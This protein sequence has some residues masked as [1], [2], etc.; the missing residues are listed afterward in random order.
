M[1]FEL[2]LG[3]LGGVEIALKALRRPM[4]PD[5]VTECVWPSDEDF[6]LMERLIR[7]GADHSKF[8]RMI[9]TGLTIKAPRYWWMEFS[10]Y[11]IGIESVSE[12]TMH[13]KVSEPFTVDD[14]EH[15]IGA[16]TLADLNKCRMDVMSDLRHKQLYQLKAMLPE[17]FLQTR[18]IVVNY[19][20]LRRMFQQRH[21]HRLPHWRK[22]C[23]MMDGFP[24]AFLIVT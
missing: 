4:N 3:H 8:A 10:T 7:R 11:R 23:S 17:G 15:D 22:F 18:D 12:S 5:F 1:T 24:L 6:V 14:F 20:T 16:E 2:E 13:R 21:D 19:Q 9:S